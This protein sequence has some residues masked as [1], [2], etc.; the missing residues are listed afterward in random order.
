MLVILKQMSSH[1]RKLYNN[2]LPTIQKQ[3]SDRKENANDIVNKLKKTF[4]IEKCLVGD[5]AFMLIVESGN[6]E[7]LKQ[8]FKS[9]NIET[10]THFKNAINW[11]KQFGYKEG[12][13]PTTER[14]TTEL[15]MIPVYK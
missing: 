11:A 15:L 9:N 13:C 12:T 4:N 1:I 2:S 6:V 8:Y 10:E 5:N 14:L 7:E 3:I